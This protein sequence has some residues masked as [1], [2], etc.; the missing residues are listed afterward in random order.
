MIATRIKPNKRMSRLRLES[1][2]GVGSFIYK[3]SA[4]IDLETNSE[5]KVMMNMQGEYLPMSNL[6]LEND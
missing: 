3:I 4:D 5:T 2:M 1:N 6:V